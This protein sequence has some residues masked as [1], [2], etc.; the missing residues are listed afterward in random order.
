MRDPIPHEDG[1][2]CLWPAHQ[3]VLQRRA[4][5]IRHREGTCPRCGRLGAPLH[6]LSRKDNHTMVCDSCGTD[7]AMLM[8]NGRNVWPDFP[9]RSTNPW[10][11]HA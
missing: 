11:D 9:K 5:P 4:H 2:E 3:E 6:A 7:E 8:A 10:S 1:S